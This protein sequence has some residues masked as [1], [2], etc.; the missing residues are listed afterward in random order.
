[1]DGQFRDRASAL[2][3]WQIA[4]HQRGFLGGG[5]GDLTKPMAGAEAFHRFK[6]DLGRHLPL[7]LQLLEKMISPSMAQMVSLGC[8][9]GAG[10]A[11]KE[12]MMCHGLVLLNRFDQICCADIADRF[13]DF[14]LLCWLGQNDDGRFYRRT[15]RL[16]TLNL[17]E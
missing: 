8:G 13:V 15:A 14:V 11:N 16:S 17:I 3:R 9:E 6:R 2:Q 7:L 4:K 1:L 10:S 12:G 5:Q